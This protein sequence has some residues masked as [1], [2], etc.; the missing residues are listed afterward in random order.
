MTQATTTTTDDRQATA[1]RYYEEGCRLVDLA[2][3][4]W[5]LTKNTS[6]DEERRA[7]ARLAY[8]QVSAKARSLFKRHDLLL[9]TI[10]RSA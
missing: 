7:G 10:A 9:D 2:T 3:E 5:D 8:E 1:D 4:Y 6:L